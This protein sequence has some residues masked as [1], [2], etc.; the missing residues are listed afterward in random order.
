MGPPTHTAPPHFARIL[1]KRRIDSDC[2]VTGVRMPSGKGLAV[3]WQHAVVPPPTDLRSWSRPAPL[4]LPSPFA[5]HS[6]Q[7]L[8]FYSSFLFFSLW[9]SSGRYTLTHNKSFDVFNCFHCSITVIS[10]P[11][12]RG[13]RILSH[14]GRLQSGPLT[15]LF[16]HPNSSFSYQ[17][18]LL[19][20]MHRIV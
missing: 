20:T 1:A 18:L 2:G 7:L 6:A 17:P 13:F 14:F 3:D 19:V 16:Q 9:R 12:A 15:A 11:A 10:G 4:L 8:F 5:P